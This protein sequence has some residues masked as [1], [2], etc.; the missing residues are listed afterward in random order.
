MED[1]LVQFI[2]SSWHGKLVSLLSILLTFTSFGTRYYAGQSITGLG[3]TDKSWEWVWAAGKVQD[4][5]SAVKCL[6]TGTQR[7]MRSD[8]IASSAHLEKTDPQPMIVLVNLCKALKPG[9]QFRPPT[10]PTIPNALPASAQASGTQSYLGGC[11]QR[12][13]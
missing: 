11:L 2:P 10:C 5:Q 9:R 1:D 4:R 13:G 12:L 7:Q 8:I 6:L 3:E